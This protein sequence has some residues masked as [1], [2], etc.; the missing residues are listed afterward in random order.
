MHS[1][2]F[3]SLVLLLVSFSGCG[4]NPPTPGVV[5]EVAPPEVEVSPDDFAK[6]MGI[7][8][9]STGR[10]V[11][12]SD[13]QYYD[14]VVDIFRRSQ[15]LPVLGAYE[16]SYAAALGVGQAEAKDIFASL[17]GL[18]F[19]VVSL[20]GIPYKAQLISGGREAYVGGSYKT[21]PPGNYRLDPV[22]R[23]AKYD[24]GSGVPTRGLLP[25]PWLRS[26]KYQNSRMYWGLWMFGGYFFHSTTHYWQLG[27]PASMGCVRQPYPDAMEN[28]TLAQSHR[29]MIRV[30]KIGS[31][32]A[33]DRLREITSVA[34]VLPKLRVN[35]VRVDESIQDIG[36][37]VV[38]LGHAWRDPQTGTPGVPVW[39]RCGPVGCFTVWGKSQPLG[40][41]A[42][43]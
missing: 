15:S 34:W 31:T 1:I 29:A 3:R 43:F 20:D 2:I 28:F 36:R 5:S 10:T 17:S 14:M 40:P 39:P 6:E 4:K 32:K 8:L 23:S 30:H 35:Q 24:N 11:A 37:E 18:E 16:P 26:A 42:D 22:M 27:V 41:L 13:F 25:F 12:E 9:A 33:Y 38:S 19:A 21:T 7:P